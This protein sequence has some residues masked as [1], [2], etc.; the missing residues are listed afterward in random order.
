MCI[1]TGIIENFRIIIEEK[2]PPGTTLATNIPVSFS[3]YLSRPRYINDRPNPRDPR[4]TVMARGLSWTIFLL[5]FDSLPLLFFLDFNHHKGFSLKPSSFTDFAQSW[6]KSW[7]EL[8]RRIFC[9]CSDQNVL[10]EPVIISI[11]VRQFNK[12]NLYNVTQ[13]LKNIRSYEPTF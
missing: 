6:T 8:W 7:T 13:L 2:S 3:S 11:S 1:Y 9:W 12:K 4:S 10:E 5:L